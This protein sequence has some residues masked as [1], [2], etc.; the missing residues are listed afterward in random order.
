[1][2]R[3]HLFYCSALV[4]I[5]AVVSYTAVSTKSAT[6]DEPSHI[7]S[8]YVALHDGD[9]RVE[10]DHPPLWKEFAALP[11][12][13]T[14]F[15]SNTGSLAFRDT[16]NNVQSVWPWCVTTLYQTPANNPDVILARSR[17]MM[18]LLG[19][20]LCALTAFFAY[21]L[22]GPIAACIAVTLFALDPN[23][24]AHSPL[25][26][27]DVPLS[28]CTTALAYSLYLLIQ[29]I[30]PLRFLAVALCCAACVTTKLTGL[31]AAPI[32]VLTFTTRALL[33]TPWPISFIR[34]SAL[35]NPRSHRLFT[36]LTLSLLL[37]LITYFAIWSAYRF[38][39]NPSPD[40]AVHYNTAQFFDRAARGDLQ[41]STGRTTVT[42][43]EFNAWRP[44]TSLQVGQW[45]LAH[46]LL[47]E[48][49]LNG[50]IFASAA[51][52]ARYAFAL[53]S[54]YLGGH[55]Y[56]FPLAFLT[57]TPLTTLAAL[58]LAALVAIF[59]KP[60]RSFSSFILLPA[61][62]ALAIPVSLFCLTAVCSNTNIGLRHLF[63]IFPLL[64]IAASISL[65]RLHTL[66]PRLTR[67][68]LPLLAVTLALETLPIYPN[69]I[70]FFNLAVGGPRAGVFLLGDS[71]LD[72]GQDL[73]L[74]AAWQR[75]N[76]T[77][78]LHL[79]YFG[80][81]DPAYYGIRYQNLP[82]G[83]RFG[84]E[85]PPHGPLPT[86]GV[87]AI[88]ASNLQRTLYP[89]SADPLYTPLLQFP[90]IEILGN[91]IYLYDLGGD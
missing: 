36:A 29:R 52:R 30:T 7:M 87:L 40:P 58:L 77:R 38:R 26:K 67:I 72:W 23:F 13:I 8:G 65:A 62:L 81:A 71:N 63:P 54:T 44:D 22:A 51:S 59:F 75:R 24:L 88:S 21:R 55:W 3:P 35:R 60:A 86:T 49:F 41:I 14:P 33:S 37:A 47:P 20:T 82:H 48:P 5:F 83:Y 85:P 50:L 42:R 6:F 11:L 9:F 78:T 18:L 66:R 57:K 16:P 2:L 68:L 45:A 70:P 4:L 1:M 27:N 73:P 91:S 34:Q 76:P 61:S 79:S 89:D 15:N 69:F 12:L 80:T 31:L 56:Y 25:V 84:T 90:P 46:H 10:P 39:F 17:F 43:R 28:L 74:L 19:V 32:L 53:G 64:Y